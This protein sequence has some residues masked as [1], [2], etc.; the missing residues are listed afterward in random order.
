MLAQ[1][2]MPTKVLKTWKSQMHVQLLIFSILKDLIKK[3]TMFKNNFL[4]ILYSTSQRV[5][6]HW[7]PLETFGW[8]RFVLHL[9]INN[10][11]PTKLCQTWLIRPWNY[12]CF[13]PL[14]KQSQLLPLLTCA[15]ISKRLWYFCIGCKLHQ[16]K[17]GS[18]PYHCWNF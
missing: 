9:L 7:A 6:T 2:L 8:K 14:L 12:T 1:H 18:V 3:Q 13:T 15:C 16:Q 10:N 4:R 11:F 5:T 17:M